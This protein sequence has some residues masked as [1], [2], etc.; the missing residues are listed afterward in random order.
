M[1]RN[2]AGRGLRRRWSLLGFVVP[3]LLIV[4]LPGLWVWPQR[5]ITASY[6][7]NPE[8]LGTPLVAVES[9]VDLDRVEQNQATF[10]QRRFSVEWHG[11]IR[12]D[13]PGLHTFETRSDDGSTLDVGDVRVVDNGGYHAERTKAGTVTLTS[14]LHPLRVRYFQAGGAYAMD[15]QWAEPGLATSGIPL[16]RLFVDP[17]GALLVFATRHVALLW[18][19]SWL[20]LAMVGVCRFVRGSEGVSR[21]PL[22][23]LGLQ[24]ATAV[25]STLF[26]FVVAE[27]ALRL[28]RY[29]QEGRHDLQILLQE[30]K[31]ADLATGTRTFASLRGVVQPSPYDGIV[32]ELKPNLRGYLFGEEL[33][34]NSRGLRD[35]E[36]TLRKPPNTVRIV[37]LGDS[38]LFGWRVPLEDTSLKVLERMLNAAGS[39]TRFEV[40]NFAVPGYN[41][42]I[43][44]EVFLRKSLQYAPDVV[45]VNFNTND[46]DVPHF[47]KQPRDYATL[48]TSLLFD[49]AYHAYT[50]RMGKRDPQLVGFDFAARSMTWEEAAR[51]HEDPDVP[52][53]YRYM[54]G[55]A[56]FER[57]M[58][59]LVEAA[60]AHGIP[61]VV[62]DVKGYPGLHP[63]YV[64][65]FR[66]DQRELLERLSRELGFRFLNTYPDYMDYLNRHPDARF[67][68]VFAVSSTDAHPNALAHAINAKALFRYL[69][70]EGLL[71][72]Q[73]TEPL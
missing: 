56:G 6:Y 49:L 26:A 30:S 5:G 50:D 18:G 14:G 16:S 7:G 23:R 13:R 29:V 53:E 57:A 69:V 10:P 66:D 40:I 25:A 9:Q 54:V 70:E 65:T 63:S 4:T 38:S 37:G 22:R 42:A 34:T 31:S 43:E 73:A 19:L 64:R 1:P 15:V 39:T 41:T 46:Y 20:A 60:D 61:V 24:V 47:M 67:P 68:R 28:G 32:Y 3:L 8:F 45:L 35:H 62:F 36:Y 55:T 59:K 58:K 44:A 72:L 21:P 2:A 27:G 71:D 51:L 48:R 11:W 12:I 17:P 33:S 52:E